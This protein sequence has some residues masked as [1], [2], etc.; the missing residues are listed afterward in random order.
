MKENPKPILPPP[1]Y[2]GWDTKEKKI[3]RLT[4]SIAYLQTKLIHIQTN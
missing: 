1:N 4:A 3:A 2:V